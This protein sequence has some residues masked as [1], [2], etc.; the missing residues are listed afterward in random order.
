MATDNPKDD[1]VEDD[2]SL[3]LLQNLSKVLT[4]QERCLT[5]YDLIPTLHRDDNPLIVEN[6]KLGLKSWCI[7]LL[8]SYVYKVYKRWKTNG[9]LTLTISVKPMVSLD[10]VVVTQIL[11]M[12]NP[13]YATAWNSRKTWITNDCLSPHE[14]IH[15][16]DIIQRKFPKSPETF[17]HRKWVVSRLLLIDD[18]KSRKIIQHELEICYVTAEKYA[19]NYSSWSH[20]IWVTQK[21]LRS[22]DFIDH[23]T[24]ELEQTKKFVSYHI[25]DYS[26]QHYKQFLLKCFSTAIPQAQFIELLTCELK[27]SKN[28]ITS[29]PDH[30]SLWQ[31]R[32]GIILLAL[33]LQDKLNIDQ[34]L[35]SDQI[36]KNECN[37]VDCDR[38]DREF[39]FL[40]NFGAERAWCE[41]HQLT[42][43]NLWVVKMAQRYTNWLQRLSHKLGHKTFL[44]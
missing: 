18:S 13:E 17:A 15:I 12:L 9:S 6:D 35:I 21:V 14:E 22:H 31:H 19:N 34:E 7:K 30:E 42:S 11:L 44:K 4:N 1:L 38:N 8:Y 5:E 27:E 25:S 16:M 40:V 24:P 3:Q 37:F 32:Q 41:A 20:R 10:V 29:F 43:S 26:A 28:L 39:T 33:H 23:V 2:F 36:S